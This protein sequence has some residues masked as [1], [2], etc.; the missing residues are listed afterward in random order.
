MKRARGGGAGVAERRWQVRRAS[1]SAE[2]AGVGEGAEAEASSG[3]RERRLGSCGKR[4]TGSASGSARG[5]G[6]KGRL[7]RRALRGAWAG[8]VGPDGLEDDVGDL[9]NRFL[10]ERRR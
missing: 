1:S 9:L 7:R 5:A 3:R 6:S 2:G 8:E 10:R 4:S